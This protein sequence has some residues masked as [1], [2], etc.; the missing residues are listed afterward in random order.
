LLNEIFE[1][2]NCQK[3]EIFYH[4]RNN[5]TDNFKEITQE[6][7]RHFKPQNKNIMRRKIIEKNVKNIIPQN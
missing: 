6:I 1:H 2:S 7:S 4:A 5:G 3:I